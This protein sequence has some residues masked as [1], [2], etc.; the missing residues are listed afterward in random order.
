MLEEVELH[1]ALSRACGEIIAIKEIRKPHFPA[2]VL[3][4]SSFSSHTHSHCGSD[5][6]CEHSFMGNLCFGD[7]FR[8]YNHLF[9]DV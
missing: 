8:E 2:F 3:S 6:D 5:K 7:L 4:D 9:V 1:V